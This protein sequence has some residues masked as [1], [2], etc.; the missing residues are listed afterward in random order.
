VNV[1]FAISMVLLILCVINCVFGMM[2]A[3]DHWRYQYLMIEITLVVAGIAIVL[4]LLG[5]EIEAR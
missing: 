5:I 1:P 3:W 4:G 2:G